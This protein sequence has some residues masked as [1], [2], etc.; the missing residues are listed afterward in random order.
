MIAHAPFDINVAIVGNV[1]AGKSTLLNAFL[2]AKYCEVSMKR[3]TAGINYFR[4]HLKKQTGPGTGRSTVKTQRTRE[5]DS[6][7]SA[8]AT[9]KEISADNAVLRNETKIQEKYFDIMVED[10]LCDMHPDTRL[11]LVD[12]PGVNE[13]CMGVKYKEFLATKWRT[14]DCVI[15]VMDG[16]Q[17]INTDDQINLLKMVKENQKVRW[18]PVI[19]LCNKVDDADDREQNEMVSE[20]CSEVE[21]IFGGKNPV[22]STKTLLASKRTDRKSIQS[23]LPAFLP[24]SAN[25]AYFHQTAPLLTL[26]QFRRFDDKELIERYGREYVGRLTWN[27]MSQEQK[28]KE[29]HQ[30]VQDPNH[31]KD[32]SEISNFGT[33]VRILAKCI[34]G[35]A[36]QLTLVADKLDANLAHVV[37][38]SREQTLTRQTAQLFTS[39]QFLSECQKDATVLSQARRKLA[40]AFWKTLENSLTTALSSLKLSPH[41]VGK[42][43][44]FM[45]E[46]ERYLQ[47]LRDCPAYGDLNGFAQ[48][49]AKATGLAQSYLDTIIS[50]APNSHDFTGFPATKGVSVAWR[51][52]TPMD[53]R[54]IWGSILLVGAEPQFYAQFGRQ[55]LVMDELLHETRLATISKSCLNSCPTCANEYTVASHGMGILRFCL[56]CKNIP[57]YKTADD[58]P[59][60]SQCLRCLGVLDQH[61]R[62]CRNCHCGSAHRELDV[63][64]YF[65]STCRACRTSAYCTGC[66]HQISPSTQLGYVTVLVAKEIVVP[67]LISDPEHFGHLPWRFCQIMKSFETSNSAPI[68]VDV[69]S[70]L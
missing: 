57:L 4:L 50:R 18:Q 53:W 45:D 14:F 10:N 9:L 41:E 42:V 56:F 28:L 7:V 11:V 70:V 16:K 27:K 13:A 48:V 38:S 52:L 62:I 31:L 26:D 33:L 43:G 51:S 64:I 68:A 66:S 54:K 32:A 65:C 47:F 37:A 17:G 44:P 63:P 1:S 39:Y 49:R 22:T 6:P 60:H 40:G 19:I 35:P 69:C 5:F 8:S 30:I 3:A 61:S 12:I 67:R 21:Q 25:H 55:K 24:F 34:G 29:I 58:N 15:V 36:G 20:A 2:R 46:L 23:L 59:K